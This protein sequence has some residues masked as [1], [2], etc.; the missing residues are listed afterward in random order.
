M[1]HHMNA[2]KMSGWALTLAAGALFA[3]NASAFGKRNKGCD[4]APAC[5]P[6]PAAACAP[7]P[8]C[9]PATKLVTVTEYQ[10]VPVQKTV[11]AYECVPVSVTKEVSCDTAS[12]S[13]CN[14]GRR[15]ACR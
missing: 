2:K 11:T 14:N 12:T 10:K 7:A 5:A 15:R 1:E 8:A 13:G 4:T 3:G 9:A 6:A